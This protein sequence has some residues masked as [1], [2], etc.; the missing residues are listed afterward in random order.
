[1]FAASGFFVILVYLAGI[2]LGVWALVVWIRVGTRWLQLHPAPGKAP[3]QPG[4]PAPSGLLPDRR[5]QQTPTQLKLEYKEAVVTWFVAN[6]PAEAL[7]ERLR[8]DA[9]TA[10]QIRRVAERI[11]AG[12]DSVDDWE[13]LRRWLPGLVEHG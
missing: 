12:T 10:G 4:G 11:A 1:M 6:E 5:Q 7:A 3:L 9:A 8:I 2:V 13:I